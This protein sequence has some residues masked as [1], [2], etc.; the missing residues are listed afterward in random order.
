M[1]CHNCKYYEDSRY[2]NNCKEFGFY[3][4]SPYYE[5]ECPYVDEKCNVNEVGK[6]IKEFL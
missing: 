2:E 1:K 4:F 6:E 3:C 5:E